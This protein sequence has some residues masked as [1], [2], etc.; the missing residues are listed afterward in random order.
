MR[1][2]ED[3][4]KKQ[5]AQGPGTRTRG[6]VLLRTY[7]LAIGQW[8]ASILQT[9]L[10]YNTSSLS[11][12]GSYNQAETSDFL[13]ATFICHVKVTRLWNTESN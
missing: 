4:R 11:Y 1:L 2:L 6:Q 5:D 12:C 3:A 9:Y 7:L 8:D 10:I 13:A